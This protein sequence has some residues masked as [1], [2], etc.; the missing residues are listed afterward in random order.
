LSK[1]TD[2]RSNTVYRV[3]LSFADDNASYSPTIDVRTGWFYLLEW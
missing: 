2:L 1:I 3:K